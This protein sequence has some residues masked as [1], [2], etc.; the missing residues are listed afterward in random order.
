VHYISDNRME[1]EKL[2]SRVEEFVN[3]VELESLRSTKP[4]NIPR[5]TSTEELVERLRQQLEEN[6]L[7]INYLE[8][9]ILKHGIPVDGSILEKE[10]NKKLDASAPPVTERKLAL[11]DD[12]SEKTV[13][14]HLGRFKDI[15]DQR[16][17]VVRYKDLSLWTMAPKTRI[18]TV[19]STIRNMLFGSGPKHRVDILKSITGK[20]NPGRLTLVIGP[21]GNSVNNCIYKQSLI[22][23]ILRLW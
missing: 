5:P 16:E 7:R 6:Q 3:S 9:L 11:F 1:E 22:I 8:S 23:K 19:G 14:A 13:R 2:N 21:P 20:I 12:A 10:D 15:V 18:K 17:I 4:S